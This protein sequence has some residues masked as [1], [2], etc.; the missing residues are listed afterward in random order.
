MK[1]FQPMR[2]ATPRALAREQIVRLIHKRGLTQGHILPTYAE[3]C[4]ILDCSLLTVQRAM[5]DLA[6]EGIVYRM[7]GKGCYVG[8][9]RKT[10]RSLLARVGLIH[11]ASLAHLIGE[12]YLNQMLIG[13]LSVCAAREIDLTIHSLRNRDCRISPQA[14]AAQTDALILIGVSNHDYLRKML[15]TKVA[16]VL[17]DGRVPDLSLD[18]VVVDNAA[19]VE[20][21][22]QT[23]M[24]A[25]HRRIAYITSKTPDPLTGRWK[26]SS[27]AVERR[28]AYDAAMNQAGLSADVRHFT[29]NNPTAPE[30]A[31]LVEALKGNNAPT[32]CLAYDAM[33]AVKTQRVLSIAGITVPRDISLAAVVGMPSDIAPGELPIDHG[34]IDFRAMGMLA[35]ETLAR[36]CGPNPPVGAQLVP[37]S[38][39]QIRGQSIATLR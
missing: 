16:M 38:A 22:L 32:A 14:L 6:Q 10:S 26:E 15:K 2:D 24:A 34:R 30:C 11:H 7:H 31:G 35:V 37:I 1:I 28:T 12:S 29:H 25:G 8:K 13:I 27:D 20:S 18:T 36:R 23:L 5:G 3:L 19:A 33:V 17:V 21:Q 9:L 4:T 39:K